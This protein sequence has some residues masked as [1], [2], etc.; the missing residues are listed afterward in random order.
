[1]LANGPAWTKTGV[2]SI[3]CIRL[4]LI[5]SLSRM[6]SEPVT[7]MSSAVITSPDRLSATTI[8]PSRRFMSP[9]SF[10]SARTAMHSDATEI[11]NPVWR[12]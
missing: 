12:S 9:R 11:S 8:F 6:A 4:G 3:V 1:M 7:P 10:A 2:P 5:A